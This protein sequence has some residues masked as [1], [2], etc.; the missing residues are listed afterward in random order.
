ME[1]TGMD[2]F[3]LEPGESYGI[4]SLHQPVDHASHPWDAAAAGVIGKPDIEWLAQRKLEWHDL[5][6]ERPAVRRKHADASTIGHG[7]II[8]AADVGF[9]H[10]EV[11][12][13]IAGEQGFEIFL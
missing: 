7:P 1:F 8:G 5:A 6:A 13:R 10:H 9:H 3:V 2:E 11:A 4:E 12:R